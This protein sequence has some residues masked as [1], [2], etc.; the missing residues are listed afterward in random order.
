VAIKDS[1]ES[2][3]RGKPVLAMVV[4][5]LIGAVVGGVIGLGVGFKVEQSRTRSDVKRLQRELKGSN[6][7][8]PHGPLGQRVGQ[9]TGSSAGSLSLKT[10]LQGAQQ[11]T[12]TATTPFE[13]TVVAK[14]GDIAVGR[15]VLVATGGH[16]VIVLPAASKLGRVV[17]SVGKDNFA[18]T[19]KNGRQIKVKLANVQKVYT[20]TPAK[21]ADAKVGADVV[22][23]GRSAG[24]NGF[25]AVE[26]I[27]LPTNSTFTA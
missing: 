25:A 10:K 15:R 13:K 14:T 22:V 16:E 1:A 3:V 6:S 20:L 17:A 2:W 18:I 11:I 23:G 8:N 7:G 24:K 19:N 4:V 12:T 27:V 9:V 26:I 5:A 21:A